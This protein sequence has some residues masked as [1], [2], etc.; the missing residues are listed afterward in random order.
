MQ[1]PDIMIARFGSRPM[2][3]GKTKVAPN[4]ATTCWAPTPMVFGQDSRSSGRTTS[5]SR[6]RFAV[7]DEFPT[8]GHRLALS[9]PRRDS[10]RTAPTAVV[11]GTLFPRARH[12]GQRSGYVA[13]TIRSAAGEAL[14]REGAG[15]FD[16]WPRV[17]SPAEAAVDKEAPLK[18][19]P[20][21]TGWPIKKGNALR[22]FPPER[23]PTPS[24][25][26]GCARAPR[27]PGLRQP[28]S[29]A[30]HGGFAP[31]R[32]QVIADTLEANVS[33]AISPST[34]SVSRRPPR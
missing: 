33:A 9:A 28:A 18:P 19:P 14:F 25:R 5:P 11:T 6:E 17:R 12:E 27:A 8:D 29:S 2:I 4:I 22:D 13:L 30:A 31:A 34:V 16:R 32:E 3:S 7:T 15:R 1:T 23:W 20:I 10:L 21:K 26:R 24:N